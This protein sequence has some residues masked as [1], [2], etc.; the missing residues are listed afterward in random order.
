MKEAFENIGKLMEHNWNLWHDIMAKSP[1]IHHADQDLA[2]Q[3]HTWV[4]T[5][6]STYDL[7]MNTWKNIVDQSE[8]TFLKMYR[9]AP[10]Y[11]ESME[12][13]VK[14]IWD[15]MKKAHHTHEE[16]IKNQFHRMESLLKKP[17]NE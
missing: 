5:L 8:D 17:E 11:T 3:W 16:S 1:W 4:T 10:W 9:Q 15:G 13:H 14:E 12:A 6:L 2:E 7:T